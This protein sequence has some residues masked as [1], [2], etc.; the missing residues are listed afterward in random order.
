M[1]DR[2]EI[3]NEKV[4]LG[5]LDYCRFLYYLVQN[6]N[7]LP[8][9]EDSLAR[10]VLVAFKQLLKLAKQ[11]G[12]GRQNWFKLPQWD[13]FRQSPRWATLLSTFQEYC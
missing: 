1:P 6:S 9:A 12:D 3:I 8:L 13:P 5:Q 10:I 2:F 11:L 4:L 7:Y